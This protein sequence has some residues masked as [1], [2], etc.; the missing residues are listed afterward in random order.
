MSR[1]TFIRTRS[2]SR[3]FSKAHQF[4]LRGSEALGIAPTL[5]V[6]DAQQQRNGDATTGHRPGEPAAFAVRF[7]V[8]LGG[9]QVLLLFGPGLCSGE[10]PDLDEVQ[11]LLQF[12]H[13]VI[14]QLVRTG[15]LAAHRMADGT[16]TTDEVALAVVI[17][18]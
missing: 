3:C 14:E 5:S 15:N 4:V 7:R 1:D 12:I 11:V 2:A 18:R 16:L 6:Q 10:R 13:R 9:R 17:H 8:G